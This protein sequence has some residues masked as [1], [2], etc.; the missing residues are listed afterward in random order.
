MMQDHDPITIERPL[1]LASASPR[2]CELLGLLG[3]AYSARVAR[4]EEAIK[5]GESA[6]EAVQ[7]FAR[8]KA[9]SV[10]QQLNPQSYSIVMG[11]DTVVVL[12]GEPLGKPK[13]AAAAEL[14]LKR[15][16][17]RAHQ[18]YTAFSLVAVPRGE[19]LECVACT[20]VTMRDYSDEEIYLYIR[21]GDPFDKAGAYAIQHPDFRPVLELNGCY[22]NVMGFP[23]C[24]LAVQLRK[25]EVVPPVDV[26]SV[27]QDKL[28]NACS[29]FALILDGT[30][31][32]CPDA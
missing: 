5:S 13:D 32:P 11:A 20:D 21:S 24:H 22:A 15:L 25:W 14:S 16:R 29:V 18:V 17:G 3:L 9:Q 23:L 31:S 4:F 7:R 6:A 2:R 27:C 12:D 19:L 10:A 26:A 30:A 28:G 1:V 8:E